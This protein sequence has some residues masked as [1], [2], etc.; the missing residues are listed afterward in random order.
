MLTSCT[1]SGARHATSPSW[2]PFA[3]QALSSGEVGP[4]TIS[5]HP[6]SAP[7]H[8]VH[9]LG[10]FKCLCSSESITAQYKIYK[11]KIISI[12]F[13]T[14]W[15]PNSVIAWQSPDWIL[16]NSLISA[17]AVV[18][19]STGRLSLLGLKGDTVLLLIIC[20]CFA[21]TQASRAA[22]ATAAD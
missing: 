15:D 1:W 4:C 3:P 10:E 6:C 8:C 19:V 13:C 18:I 22:A 5:P 21:Y 12:L 17:I 16:V 7:C 20:Q 9:S 11:T 2:D 14:A